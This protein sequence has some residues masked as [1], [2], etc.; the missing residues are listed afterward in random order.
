MLSGICRALWL[1]SYVRLVS[2]VL[3]LVRLWLMALSR[4]LDSCRGRGQA[5]LDD[6]SCEN[7][8][9]LHDVDTLQN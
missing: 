6:T 3:V 4:A 5:L 9:G 8:T 2:R 7:L 1:M